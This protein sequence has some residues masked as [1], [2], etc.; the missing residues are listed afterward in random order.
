M[1]INIKKLFAKETKLG[2]YEYIK[3]FFLLIFVFLL[4]VFAIIVIPPDKI[5]LS[6][7]FLSIMSICTVIGIV[8]FLAATYKRF[9]D[10]FN[11]TAASI[12][13]IMVYVFC[14]P[15]KVVFLPLNILLF[16]MPGKNKS[17][18]IISNKTVFIT[19]LVVLL[20]FI[21]YRTLG[22]YRHIEMDGMRD[23]VIPHD[24]IYINVFNKD[25]KR[26]DIIIYKAD[27]A[28]FIS[29][30]VALPGEKVEIKELSDGTSAIYINGKKL[31]EPYVKNKKYSNIDYPSVP[32]PKDSYY[33]IGDNRRGSNVKRIS[34]VSKNRIQGRAMHIWFPPKRRQVI[35][36]PKYNLNDNQE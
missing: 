29:R 36:S 1:F 5:I 16:F 12:V 32:V 8:I 35:S 4:F 31:E 34:S 18:K 28:F 26:G 13:L 2:R 20:I 3:T 7:L 10:I 23:T 15:I 25:Y 21:S 19:F 6:Y 11:K 22:M 27:K 9:S 33:I 17:D 24:F 14:M 30:I